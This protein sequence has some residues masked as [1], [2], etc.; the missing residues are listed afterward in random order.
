MKKTFLLL[1]LTIFATS[2]STMNVSTDTASVNPSTI[3]NPV[4]V[5]IT[6]DPNQKVSGT[7]KSTYFLYFLRLSGDNQFADGNFKGKGGGVKSAAHF[8]ALKSSGADVLINPQYEVKTT[9]GLF[10]LWRTVEAK[11]TG[12]KGTYKISN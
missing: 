12:H 3:S 10:F 7:S 6:V 9:N 1:S 5:D 4:K 2:C 11:V 8:N